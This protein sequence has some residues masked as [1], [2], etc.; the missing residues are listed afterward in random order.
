MSLVRRKV[1]FRQKLFQSQVAIPSVKFGGYDLYDTGDTKFPIVYI[2]FFFVNN[3]LN[4]FCRD[5][6]STVSVETGNC[7]LNIRGAEMGE[8]IVRSEWD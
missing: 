5:W 2:Y 4:H 3:W 7:F 6:R 8:L 1:L